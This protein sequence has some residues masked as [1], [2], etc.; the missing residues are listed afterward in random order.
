[1]GVLGAAGFPQPLAIE[2]I[3]KFGGVVA[4]GVEYGA[5]PTVDVGGVDTGLWS[6]AGDLRVLPLGGPFFIGIRAGRQHF[7]ATAT[8]SV[9]GLGNITESAGLDQWFVNPRLGFL[10]TTREGFAIGFNAGIEV[11]LSSTFS[12]TVPI[13]AGTQVASVTN[14]VLQVL[15]GPLPTIDL[16]QIGL[17]L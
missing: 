6:L 11:P 10:W 8:L 9:Q 2:A 1:V 7:G 17:L 13:P 14:E 15:G 4:A 16:L 12:S 3:M 5:M